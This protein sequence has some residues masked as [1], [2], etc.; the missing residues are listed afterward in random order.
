MAIAGCS[1]PQNKTDQT[2]GDTDLNKT[3]EET[4]E[5][6]DQRSQEIQNAV[7]R[8]EKTLDSTYSSLED[9]QL[10]SFDSSDADGL[11]SIHLDMEEVYT[12]TS[13]FDGF[14]RQNMKYIHE[15]DQTDQFAEDITVPVTEAFM[16][17]A[18]NL[19]DH[20]EDYELLNIEIAGADETAFELTIDSDRTES[21]SKRMNSDI[22][23][24]KSPSVEMEKALKD[25]GSI[26]WDSSMYES[27]VYV[28]D[29]ESKTVDL[30]GKEIEVELED[31]SVNG[32]AIRVGIDR[33]TREY[34]HT[35]DT[36]YRIEDDIFLSTEE[37]NP[38]NQRYGQGASFRV[39]RGPTDC[40]RELTL[41]SGK[42]ITYELGQEE[43]NIEYLGS[44]DSTSA[45][46]R[47]DGKTVE[48]SENDR[49]EVKNVVYHA[50]DIFQTA[51]NE[52]IMKIEASYNCF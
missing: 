4:L 2:S 29:G 3:V 6:E 7:N 17:A 30:D 37:I 45:T 20:T 50:D 15:A 25:H 11:V 34:F 5:P 52:G 32:D 31:V 16:V 27:R 42:E 28:P 12:Q 10:V 24:N 1:A 13:V 47:S 35:E 8:I 49:K 19:E 18:S 33:N 40:S 36:D 23:S 14:E 44:Q 48:I 21:L 41:E 22:E 51:D 46:I 9:E 43:H 38:L 26:S 39:T